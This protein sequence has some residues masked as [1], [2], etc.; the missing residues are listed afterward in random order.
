MQ[1]SHGSRPKYALAAYALLCL[2]VAV[3][4]TYQI[5]AS[6]SLL[7]GYFDLRHQ[8][9]APFE[10]D[11]N[12]PVVTTVGKAAKRAGMS[13][14]DTVLFLN[15]EPYRGRALWQRQRWYAHIGDIWHLAV[16]HPNGIYSNVAI[17]L[18]GYPKSAT[19]NPFLN[20]APVEEVIFVVFMQI[21]VPLFCLGLGYWVAL[22]RPEDPNAWFI[23]ILLSYPEAFISVSTFNWWPGIWLP[24]RLIWHV[25]LEIVAPAALLC[26]GL[27]FP[28]RSRIDIRFPLLKWLVLAVLLCSLGVAIAVEHTAWY[29][30]GLIP[31]ATTIDHINDEVINWT[32][33]LCI[34][35]YWI[36]IF[37]K[38]RTALTPDSR[39][40]LRVLCAGSVV[41]LGSVLFIFGALPLF[42]I[43]GPGSIQWLGYLSAVL[44]LAFPLSLAY[45][46]V[47]QRALDVRILVRLGTKYALARGTVLILRSALLLLIGIFIW[48]MAR[49]PQL[50]VTDIVRLLVLAALLVLISPRIFKS[51]SSW[52]DRQFFREAYNADLVLSELSE[53]V[54]SFT[55]TATLVEMVSR[56]IS[57]VLHVPEVSVLLRVENEFYLS[58]SPS[59]PRAY[60]LSLA[61]Q[62]RSVRRLLETNRPAVV[63]QENAEGWLI[64][65]EPQE[66]DTLDRLQAEVLLALPGRERLMGIMVLGPKRSEEPYSVSDLRVLQ[67][68]GV[69]TGLA[70]E[71]SELARSLAQELSQRARMDRE[72]E[73]AREVQQRFFPRQMPQI[74]G[75]DVAGGCLPALGVGG[76]Y[77]DYLSVPTG[78]T[79]LAIGDIAGKGIAAALLM[80]GLQASLRGLTLAGVS[81]LSDLMAKLNMLVYDATPKN[82]FATFF[83]G[84]FDPE[85]RSLRYSSAGHN[86]VL[87]YRKKRDETVWLKTPGV[88][89]GLRRTSTYVA[90][91]VV[92]ELGDELFLYTDGVTEARNSS[93]EEFGENRLE[94]VVRVCAGNSADETLTR[95]L[96]AVETFAAGETQ[97]DDITVIV[98]RA[99]PV[100]V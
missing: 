76:D 20:G 96:A 82:R 77:Y 94:Q 62:S 39:R 93:G 72:M 1:R 40:R 36:A 55:E 25:S 90:E 83:Y 95:L 17:P 64:Q 15:G 87:L 13:P 9:Q 99:V 18:E 53:Q 5:V 98:A 34:A 54:R 68:V 88:A 73:I 52:L 69:Q 74:H 43:A 51:I 79:G 46:V 86:A 63:Y 71:A 37:D 19:A 70:L 26:L 11:G 60:G 10:V 3:T 6:V 91:E 2:Y 28:D 89:L 35:V 66:R 100:A 44:M 78:M 22:A 65:A 50:G 21:V 30:F 14:G 85:N 81:D 27:L 23:L 75:L 8:V 59:T 7:V 33:L 42:G 12:G 58:D 4:F 47:V 31:N 84:V 92:L 24:L 49:A 57:D 97:H 48:Q 61:E 41:G 80:A 16:R 29:H 38:L 56:R 67:S 45:V 32:T